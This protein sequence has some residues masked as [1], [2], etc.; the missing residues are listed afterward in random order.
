MRIGLFVTW[1]ISQQARN[2]NSIRLHIPRAIRVV[3]DVRNNRDAAHLG[4]NID[5]NLQD[6]SLVIAN[7]D[8]ILAEF[9]RNYHRVTADEAQ[10]IV[11]SLVARRVP[12]IQDFGGFLKVLNPRLRVSEFALLLL[13]E[14]GTAGASYQELEGWVRPAMTSN[15][16][17][18][19]TRLVHDA[20]SVHNDQATGRYFITK[21]GI[22]EVEDRNLHNIE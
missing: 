9:V 11:D 10:R 5:P 7:L 8:W 6:A 15:L 21:R 16:R 19:L 4:D 12:A 3:Y 14:R 22:R 20:A 17:R 18:T 2:L 1:V 13:Y